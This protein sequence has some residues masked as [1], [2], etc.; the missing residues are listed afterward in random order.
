MNTGLDWEMNLI[1]NKVGIEMKLVCDM[2]NK[3]NCGTI[4]NNEMNFED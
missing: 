3:L 4:I 2:N 1:K